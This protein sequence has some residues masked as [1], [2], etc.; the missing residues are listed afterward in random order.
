[1]NSHWVL[2]D[3]EFESQ[4]TNM[5]LEPQLFTHEAHLRLAWIHINKYGLDQAIDNI[6]N[7]IFAYVENL[8][9]VDKFNLTLTISA[10]KIVNHFNNKSTVNSFGHFI[11]NNSR[12]KNNFKELLD[13]HYGFDIINSKEAKIKYVSPDLLPFE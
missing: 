12:L 8:N 7:Q 9:S 2:S 5:T 1:M 6:V 10:L 11:E 13:S 4:F 3:L